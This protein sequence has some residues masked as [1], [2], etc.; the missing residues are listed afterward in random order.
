MLMTL[1]SACWKYDQ[2]VDDNSPSGYVF[3][4]WLKYY[5]HHHVHVG[6]FDLLDVFAVVK[7]EVS[8]QGVW[9]LVSST[10]RLQEVTAKSLFQ[11]VK[12]DI[13][14]EVKTGPFVTANACAERKIDNSFFHLVHNQHVD[15][16]NPIRDGVSQF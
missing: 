13:R 4:E 1:H 7:M 9:Q 8:P 3:E 12:K 10:P 6:C 14:A 11:S 5:G 15:L 2:V 16:Y